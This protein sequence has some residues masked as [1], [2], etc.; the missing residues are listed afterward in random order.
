MPLAICSVRL[1]TSSPRR[2][3]WMLSRLRL[4][5]LARS[6]VSR[7]SLAASAD[8]AECTHLTAYGLEGEARSLPIP[9]TWLIINKNKYLTSFA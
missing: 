4:S 9:Y 3:W 8:S 2:Y 6:L 5:I 7:A 1:V